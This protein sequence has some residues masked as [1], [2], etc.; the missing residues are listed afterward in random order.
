MRQTLEVI[1]D[2]TS[3]YFNHS[4]DDNLAFYN[5]NKQE[6]NSLLA[7]GSLNQMVDSSDNAIDNIE[8]FT[9]GNKD[10]MFGFLS[11]DLKNQLEDLETLYTSQVDFPLCHFFVPRFVFEIFP[12]KVVAH[13][14]ESENKADEV[15]EMIQRLFV[16]NIHLKSRKYLTNVA[17]RPRQSI[18]EYLYA[19][20]KLKKHIQ[21]GDIYEI[22]YCQE[23]FAKDVR[24]NPEDIYWR[25]NDLTKAPFSAFYKLKDKFALCGSPERYLKRAGTKLMS[26][27][28]KGTIKRGKDESEDDVLKK[29]LR[30]DPK[31]Q[32]EN[33]MIVDLVRNDLSKIANKGSVKVDELY[34]VYSFETVHQL[35]ST[36]SCQIPEETTFMET[37]KASFPMGSMTGA[38]KVRAME[39][40]DEYEASARGLYSGSIGFI[41]PNK[42]FDFNVVIRTL[43]YNQKKEFL[44]FTV[45]GAIT[46]LSKPEKEYEECMLK[47]KALITAIGQM[48]M[49]SI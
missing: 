22:N 8:K 43:L 40:A 39:L 41:K 47:A 19:V 29:Q 1:I 13:Y 36:I 9:N 38:P 37:I 35:I 48:G 3:L 14:H 32:A 31:E 18:H 28:I 46:D 26:Q 15:Q 25:L 20:K 44:S 33:V 30:N 5:N 12:D 45:G 34:G 49:A 7:I 23:F 21:Q 17:V 4:L 24:L 16:A 42:D 10:W 11:Y 6:G 27:P 2:T